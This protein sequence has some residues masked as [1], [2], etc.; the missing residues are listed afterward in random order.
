[1]PNRVRIVAVRDNERAELQRRARS[2]AEPA[3]VAQ[4]ARIVLLAERGLTGP[5]IAERVGCSEPTV[6]LWRDRYARWG[7][8]GLA[9]APRSGGPVRVMTP[10]VQAEILAVTVTPPPEALG[11]RGLTHWSARRLADWLVRHRD[12]RVSHDSIAV[13]WRQFCLPAPPQRGV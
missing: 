1:M 3:R 12:I 13:L 7:L 5:Q 4:R 2:K 8:A 9:D 10:E 11:E 6:V